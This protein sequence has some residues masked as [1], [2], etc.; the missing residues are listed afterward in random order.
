MKQYVID[1]FADKPFT[2]NQAAICV[3][4][5]WPRD[6]FMRAMALENNFS[7][8]AFLLPKGSGYGLRW[9]TPKGEI[10]LCGHATLAAAFTVREIVEPGREG[11]TF[12]TASGPLTVAHRG[13]AYEM[14][15]PAFAL[16]RVPVTPAMAEALGATPIEAWMG[17][18]LVCV[19]EDESAV[20]SLAPDV[21]RVA[22]LDG[23]LCHVTAAGSGVYDCVSRSFAPKMGV[24]ED[25][26]CGSGHCH[27]FPYWSG[28]LGKERLLGWQASPRGGALTGAVHNGRVTL[29]GSA[30]L[31]CT[32]DVAVEPDAAE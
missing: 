25:P 20:R 32:A 23:L 27:I 30:T 4:D 24:A 19:M 1:A 6:A 18:D 12:D 8:T 21:E 11:V 14:D 28:R 17:R 15:F 31:F 9:F 2:G 16:K 3:V 22:K 10:D 7:E 13:S 29:G 5:A 26:V